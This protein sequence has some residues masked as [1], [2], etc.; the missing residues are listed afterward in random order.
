[1][2]HYISL[3]SDTWID[4]LS[5][6]GLPASALYAICMLAW[7]LI[8]GNVNWFYVDWVYVY[9]VWDRW[10]SLNVGMLAFISSIVAFNISRYNAEKQRERDFLA[11]KAFLPAA[12]SELTSYFKAS[13]KVFSTGWELEPGC[14]PNF[15]VP[16][17]PGDYKTVFSDCIRHAEPRVG[18]YLTQILIKLQVHEAR[19]KS[20]VNQFN[21]QNYLDL[22]KRN[23]IVYIYKL[24]ELH[25]LVNK[26][27][28]YA[29]NMGEFDSMPLNWED[30]QN[31]YVNLD[32]WIDDIKIND[33]MNL[34][35]FTMRTIERDSCENN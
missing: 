33:K 34:K 26:L 20:Y 27:F 7:P 28:E 19:L 25:T 30:F 5:F 2:K 4:L 18:D 35:A 14:S 21:D 8:A 22:N 6:V 31:A 11:S 1:M 17:L 12:L 10:Q 24:G 29:R 3:K 13:A 9:S 15:V 32:F 16:E 23:L